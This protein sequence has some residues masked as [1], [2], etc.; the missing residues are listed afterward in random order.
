MILGDVVCGHGTPSWWARLQCGDM[1]DGRDKDRR[2][3]AACVERIE[4]KRKLGG[5]DNNDRDSKCS[6]PRGDGRLEFRVKIS[7]EGWS[8]DWDIWLHSQKDIAELAPR[9]TH[10]KMSLMPPP[11]THENFQLS[12]RGSSTH[13]TPRTSAAAET[14]PSSSDASDDVDVSTDLSSAAGSEGTP[15]CDS[16]VKESWDLNSSL[17]PVEFAISGRDQL[18][19]PTF[20]SGGSVLMRARVRAWKV[21]DVA[22]WVASTLELPQYQKHFKKASVDGL[23]LLRVGREDLDAIGVGDKLHALKILSHLDDMRA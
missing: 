16:G 6:S 17:S 22:A 2:W 7:F 10:V 3:Y 14:P 20:T 8:S 13:A 23:M 11:V 9:G 4:G 1:V 12:S 5:G 15:R 19:P 18:A 21:A